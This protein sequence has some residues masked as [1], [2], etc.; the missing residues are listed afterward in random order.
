[1]NS[2]AR[3]KLFTICSVLAM[4]ACS[5]PASNDAAPAPVE[6]TISVTDYERA[7]RFLA[8]NTAELVH[9]AIL[10]QYWQED[11]SLIYRRSTEEGLDYVRVDAQTGQRSELLDVART[12]EALAEFSEEEIDVSELSLSVIELAEDG[13]ILEFDYEGER[14]AL[15][16]ASYGVDQLA[17]T[18]PDEYLSPDGSK[19]AF[20]DEHN[21]WLRDTASNALTQLTFDGEQDYGYATNNAG[22]LRD[23]G[24][25]LLW[26]PDSERI[27]T[28]RHDGRNVGEMHLWTTQVGHSE[29][30]AWKYPLPGDDYIFMIE[31][32]VIHLED[33]PRIVRLNMPPD[34][35][36]STTSDHIA[37]RGG[38][39]LD[40]EWSED[41][42]TLSFVSSSRDHKIAQLQ[43]A[44]A[45]TGEVRPVYREEVDTYYESGFS[46]ANWRVFPERGEF[47][48]FSEKD[49]WGHL[50]LHDL[51]SG[52]LKRRITEGSWAVLDIQQ[53][54][55]DAEQIYFTGSNR[56]PGDPYY[57]YLYRIDFDGSGLTNLTPEAANHQ[58]S[59]SDSGDFF[60]DIYSTPTTAPIAVLRDR[61]GEQLLVLEETSIE[62]LIE[63]GWVAP[64]PFTVKA[65]DQITDIYGLLY[66]P[67]NFDETRSYPILNYLYPGP[68]S[69]SVGT[70][71]FRASR[72]DKQALAELG[73]VVVELDAMG[74]PGRSKSFH[75]A[76]YG[77]MGDNGLPDQIAGI[78]Q[79]AAQNPWMDLDRV[80]IWG[81]SG[82]GFASTAG[83]LR[84]PD[85][86]KVA[87]SGAGNHDNR[88]YEDDWGEKWQGL[89]E[90]Y[91]ETDPTDGEATVTTN[92]DN[93]ANQL[94]ADQLEGK[95]LLAHGMLDTNVHPSSTLLVVDALI[96]ADKDFDLVVLPN[97][98]HG[99]GNGRYFM[100][101]RW[102]YF[103]EH[104]R[105]LQPPASF[106][107]ADNI[108]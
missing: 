48:W 108:D 15:D 41:S 87:V 58:I 81:H 45:Q 51:Q 95:L 62:A 2:T 35:H 12:A 34:P 60:T 99:F 97:A 17:E 42:E 77:N 76:Y 71:S 69:G 55:L 43:V 49:N 13:D 102:D 37:G 57:Q 84:Y 24:P 56:E 70:R 54:D 50:Y 106:L 14:Y 89:L 27:A 3:R 39:F 59:W 11:D 91:P 92:Y 8:V 21:L 22:W 20:I 46:S 40:V 29:L 96:E 66:K 4:Q 101:R 103:V 75:D 65:R 53:V 73:F 16:L 25:V 28:F 85:F 67:S 82:G 19:A 6:E 100:K 23:D 10:A 32:I 98:G 44:D 1:M 105:G 93:Q 90:T 104:L 64:V 61:A 72:N 26:S 18:P 107:F 36:R 38:V 33:E 79:L 63:S 88:N 52:E 74:T 5:P 30:D 47:I 9:N 80:G 83:I 31:R 78:R 7:E 94:L 86:Y 68:Q